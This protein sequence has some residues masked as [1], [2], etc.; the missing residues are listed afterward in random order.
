[1]K[2]THNATLQCVLTPWLPG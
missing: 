1:V 2:I